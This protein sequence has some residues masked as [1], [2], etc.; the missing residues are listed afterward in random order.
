MPPGATPPQA[1]V[2]PDLD[3]APELDRADQYDSQCELGVL[4]EFSV[5]KGLEVMRETLAPLVQRVA[6]FI[7]YGCNNDSPPR[8]S[9]A[10]VVPRCRNSR[11]DRDH[12]RELLG[13]G[14]LTGVEA[15][16]TQLCADHPW[17]AER[18]QIVRLAPTEA[19]GRYL[20]D[21][22]EVE[23]RASTPGTE[24]VAGESTGPVVV[25][26]V[27]NEVLLVVFLAQCSQDLPEEEDSLSLQPCG[28]SPSSRGG[29]SPAM[30]PTPSRKGSQSFDPGKLVC[31]EECVGRGGF[32]A[33]YRGVYNGRQVAV[34]RLFVQGTL[35]EQQRQALR[36]EV[37]S[38]SRLRPHRRL[39]GFIGACEEPSLLIVTEFMPNG[40]LHNLLHVSK[41]ALA[42]DRQLGMATQVTEGVV[43]LH[44][45]GLIHRD[46]KSMNILLDDACNVKICDFGLAV[47]L[48]L[49]S[50][51]LTVS[52]ANDCG[53]PRYLAP[54]LFEATKRITA[55]VDVW[56][57]G[58][59]LNEI[60]GGSYP[61]PEC[62]S[63]AQ[64]AHAVTVQRRTP[65]FAPCLTR[66]QRAA[67]AACWRYDPQERSSSAEVLAA[68]QQMA[69]GST[70]EGSP[71]SKW[72][73][74]PPPAPPPPLATSGLSDTTGPF[75]GSHH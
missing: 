63:I 39:V 9:Q 45:E 26:G 27:G 49:F 22:R 53:S 41:T 50:S 1:G 24:A 38:L 14:Q 64:I 34:K 20:V 52:A 46:L 58:C 67:I 6:A 72:P 54:E 5:E 10:A 62:R 31:S 51:H 18:H 8:K 19:G 32:G 29:S 11:D 60:L 36:K 47:T 33:V 69:G 3:V 25:D 12:R 43:H 61:W 23:I 56:S 21:G 2:L 7:D 15:E 42:A 37:A 44:D 68:L 74:P 57:L 4:P 71:V 28:V 70:F 59:I 13:P 17:V 30:A 73:P 55:K 35:T 48:G 66:G 65:D 16:L 75:F 40:S